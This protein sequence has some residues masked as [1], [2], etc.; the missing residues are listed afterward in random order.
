MEHIR[1]QH[2]IHKF[3]VFHMSYLYAF[4]I[5]S[6]KFFLNVSIVQSKDNFWEKLFQSITPA[7]F[8]V[9]LV[10]VRLIIGTCYKFNRLPSEMVMNISI[11]FKHTI[12]Y[13]RKFLMIKFKHES[14]NEVICD[15]M[16]FHNF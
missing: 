6:F 16:H 2:V 1:N 12:K 11:E 10:R 14:N 8:T 9:I 13:F 15:I 4:I 3:L 7:Y 5:Q